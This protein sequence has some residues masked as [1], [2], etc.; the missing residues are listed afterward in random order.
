MP[1]YTATF[2]ITGAQ[3]PLQQ[4]PPSTCLGTLFDY[5]TPGVTKITMQ[6]YLLKLL[7]E[8]GVA[9]C[10]TVST[11]LP[12]GYSAQASQMASTPAEES[13]CVLKVNTMQL[14]SGCALRT[15]GCTRLYL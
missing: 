4:L 5:T 1:W 6:A 7:A 14:M 9:S 12:P 15:G 10:N 3:T 2:T 8:H 13:A 11:P